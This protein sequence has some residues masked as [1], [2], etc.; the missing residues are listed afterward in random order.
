M[1]TMIQPPAE[2]SFRQTIAHHSRSFA[3]ASKLLPPA[4]RRDALVLYAYCRRADDAVDLTPR[5]ERPAALAALRDELDEVYAPMRQTTQGDPVTRAFAEVVRRHQIPRSYPEALVAGMAMDVAGVRYQHWADLQ[6]YSYCVA[7][8]VGRM[9]CHVMGVSDENA[10]QHAEDLG[11]G[12]QLTNICR[13]VLEDWQ[14]GRLYLPADVLERYGEGTLGA[15]LGGPLPAQASPAI[16]LAIA[17]VLDRAED[18]YRSGD[19]GLRYLSP[20]CRLAIRTARLVYSS[21]GDEL[22]RRGCDP[23]VG[24][25]FVPTHRKLALAARAALDILRPQRFASTGATP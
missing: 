23:R 25:V 21:I 9:M 14:Q 4:A 2:L 13:D 5:A 7:G 18:F 19:A 11:I 10:L 12:M 1:R 17:H 15:A 6:R 8:T 16:A 20:R 24:R 3:L 22:R